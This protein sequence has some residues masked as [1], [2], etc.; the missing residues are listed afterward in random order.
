MTHPS[1]DLP[2]VDL[3]NCER[4]P[5]HIPGSIQPHGVLFVLRQPGL[6]VSHVSESVLAHCGASAESV[7]GAPLA[8]VIDAAA[9]AELEARL[10]ADELSSASALRVIAAG[11]RFDGVAHRHAGLTFLELE[12]SHAQA[13]GSDTHGALLRALDELPRA[14]DLPALAATVVARVR[15]LTGFERVLFYR[16]DEQGHGS[17]EAESKADALD[18]Y[19]GLRYPASDIPRQAR[20]L[21]LRNWIRVIPDA[22]YTP[23]RLVAEQREGTGAPVD[24]SF[25]VLRSVSPVHLEYLANM[26][27][28]ASMSISLVVG[29]QLWGLISCAHHS[30]PRFVPYGVRSACEAIGRL[31]SLQIA[32]LGERERARGAEARRPLLSLLSQAMREA[33]AE[34]VLSPLSDC[35]DALLELVGATGAAILGEGKPRR[36]GRTPDEGLLLELGRWLEQRGQTEPFAT[37]TLAAELPPARAAAAEASGLLS[38][39]LP[40]VVTR[41][42]LWFRPELVHTVAW[43]GNP[44]EPAVL[45]E[46]VRLHPR[47]S[48]EQWKEEVRLSAEPWSLA[49][50]DAAEELRRRAV[51]IDLERQL[52]RARKAVR[53]RD[54]LVAVV[55]HDLRNPLNVIQMQAALLLQWGLAQLEEAPARRLRASAER[56]QRACDHM[57][58]LVTDLLDLAKIEAGRFELSRTTV[59]GRE[60]VDESLVIVRPL[61]E[62]KHI[63]LEERLIDSCLVEADRERIFQVLSN[64]TGNAIKF[65]PSGGT[66][67]VETCCEDEEMWISVTD[68]GPGI[69]EEQREAIFERYWQAP[70]SQR[71]GGTGLGLYIAKG[72]VEAHDGRI[73]AERAPTGG[74]R[75]TF[76]LPCKG[77]SRMPS[78]R[79]GAPG[80]MF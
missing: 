48:F 39:A 42:V 1:A 25:A 57:L 19:L 26:G 45:D 52:V 4:E 24:L 9:V 40:G 66:I 12:P 73:W 27:V 37:R 65:T 59:D 7:L 20:E 61:A 47:R 5:I 44:H 50:L 79:P 67:T 71:S 62:A 68:T 10:G 2:P 17:V 6:I 77:S 53:L 15:A 36:I 41:H 33:E 75:F 51:E 11:A 18:P 21:Y 69:P 64:L 72:V 16:F 8:S 78:F 38:I 49:D 58:S 28:R 80:R 13:D 29:G 32:A 63:T 43:G 54:D 55:S 60:L 34:D 14:L 22:R 3:T 56:V 23:S 31:V 70:R 30:G 74:A 46:K 35:S 76:T